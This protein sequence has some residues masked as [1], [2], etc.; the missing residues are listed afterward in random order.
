M[1]PEAWTWGPNATM[2]HEAMHALGFFH[3]HSRPDRDEHVEI[4]PSLAQDGNYAKLT[5]ENWVNT[6]S[7]YDFCSIM[8]YTSHLVSGSDEYTISLAGSNYK[9]PT[10][11]TSNSYPFSE[12]DIKQINYAYCSGKGRL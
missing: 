7:P 8:H 5:P 10:I 4:H 11:A 6:S 9:T 2:Q 12:E 1:C 3:E